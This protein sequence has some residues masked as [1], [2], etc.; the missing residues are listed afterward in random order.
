MSTLVRATLLVP[1]PAD[2]LILTLYRS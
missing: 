2:I 1:V